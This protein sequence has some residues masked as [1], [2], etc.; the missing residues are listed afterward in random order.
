MTLSLKVN[1]FCPAD[2]LDQP[3]KAAAKAFPESAPD[4]V[5]H[6]VPFVEKLTLDPLV[7]VTDRSLLFRQVNVPKPDNVTCSISVNGVADARVK[8]IVPV[9]PAPEMATLLTA[10]EAVPEMVQVVPVTVPLRI[11]PVLSPE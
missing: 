2:G 4:P 3:P 8:V 5:V 6:V 1:P 10:A 9:D 7:D 11:E